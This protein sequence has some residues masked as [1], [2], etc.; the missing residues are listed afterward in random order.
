MTRYGNCVSCDFPIYA[1]NEN[2]VTCPSCKTINAPITLG[3]LIIGTVALPLLLGFGA[4]VVGWIGKA[5]VKKGAAFA[6][7]ALGPPAIDYGA[8]WAKKKFDKE[9]E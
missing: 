2:P 9:K 7:G 1:P 6:A 5:T 8:Q 4:F 3:P